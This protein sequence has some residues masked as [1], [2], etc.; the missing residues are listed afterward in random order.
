MARKHKNYSTEFKLEAIRLYESSGR[1]VR[2]LED[3]LGLSSGL[4][5]LWLKKYQAGG[6]EAVQGGLAS[7]ADQARIRALER[8]VKRLEQERDILK[9]AMAIFTQ[10]EA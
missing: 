3:E 8:E 2:Q 7:Q 5:R 4:L 9:K 6:A 10:D 1:A